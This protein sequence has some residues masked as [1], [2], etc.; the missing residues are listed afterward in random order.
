MYISSVE[1]KSVQFHCLDILEN[2]DGSDWKKKFKEVSTYLPK[3][4]GKL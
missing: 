3:E 1:N 4:T 2:T